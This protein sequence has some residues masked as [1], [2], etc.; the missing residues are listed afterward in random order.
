LRSTEVLLNLSYA[1]DQHF[2]RGSGSADAT[3]G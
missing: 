1:H 2:E 3:R